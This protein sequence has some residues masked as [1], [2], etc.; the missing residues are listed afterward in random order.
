MTR[1]SAR[2][3]V[4]L[5]AALAL[6]LPGLALGQSIPVTLSGPASSMVGV[7]FVAPIQVDLS[8]RTERLGSFALRIKWNP[9]VV[10]LKGGANGTF[11]DVI[12]YDD[13]IPFGVIHMSGVNPAGVGGKVVLAVPRFNPKVA[14]TTTFVVTLQ[15]LYA[16]GTFA[17]LRPDAVVSNRSYCPARGRFGDIESDGQITSRDGLLA[18]MTA[19]GLPTPGFDGTVGDVDGDGQTTPRDALIILSNVVGLD[20]SPFRLLRVAP[21]A[22]GVDQLRLLA[23]RPGDQELVTGQ[24]IRFEAY[25]TDANTNSQTLT[26]LAW[27]TSN[28]AVATVADGNVTAATPGSA[29]VTAKEPGG[30]QGSVTITVIGARHTH[31][32][33][34]LAIAEANRTGSSTLPFATIKEGLSFAAANDTVRVRAGR[35]VEQPRITVPVV[36]HGETSGQNRAVIASGARTGA[37]TALRVGAGARYEVRNLVLEAFGLGVSAVGTDTAVIDSLEFNGFPGPC[38]TGAVLAR[39][40]HVLRVQHSS[41]FGGGQSACDDGI[42]VIDSARLVVVEDTHISYFASNGIYLQTVDSAV[43]RRSVIQDDQYGLQAYATN[44]THPTV[45]LL[46]EDNRFQRNY[47]G[48]VYALSLR[49]MGTARNVFDQVNQYYPAYQVAGTTAGGGYIRISAD[50]VLGHNIGSYSYYG[51][52]V[53]ANGFDSAGVDGMRVIGAG[54]GT[55][56]NVRH[57]RVTNSSFTEMDNVQAIYVSNA[58]VG[59]VVVDSVHITGSSLCGRCGY[60]V[61]TYNVDSTFVNRLRAENLSYGVYAGDSAVTVTNSVFNNVYQAVYAYGDYDPSPLVVQNVTGSNVGYGIGADGMT[62]RIDGVV[63]AA[64]RSQDGTGINLY[65]GRAD[66]VRNSSLADFGDGV[67]FYGTSMYAS[68]N[69]VLRPSSD[70]FYAEGTGVT[71]SVTLLNNSVTCDGSGAESAGGVDGYAGNHR[72]EGNTVSGCGWG[73]YIEGGIAGAGVRLRNNTIALSTLAEDPGVWIGERYRAEVVGNTISGG[74]QYYSGSIHLNGTLPGRLPY[75]R[76]DSNTIRNAQVWAIRTSYV[77][78]LHVRGNLIEDLTQPCCNATAGAISVEYSRY[79]LQIKKNT[80]HRIHGHGMTINQGFDSATAVVD[81]NAISGAD[82]AAVRVVAGSLLMR[83]NNIRNNARNGVTIPDAA[84]GFTLVGNAFKGNLLYAVQSDGASV[85]AQG[86]WWGV[87]GALPGT[88]GADAVAGSV[89]ASSPLGSE[90]TDVPS[91]APPFMIA[92]P[93]PSTPI[94]AARLPDATRLGAAAAKIA[95]SERSTSPVQFVAPSRTTVRSVDPA[96]VAAGAQQAQQDE[97]LE[98]ARAVVRERANLA[99]AA[100]QAADTLRAAARERR[101]ADRKVAP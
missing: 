57:L 31:W 18:L 56:S 71:D 34:A 75:A 9:A 63:F 10:E 33:D 51:G 72:Y 59:S 25:G 40:V 19:V 3:L 95:R 29:L 45:A 88:A 62:S 37:D 74:A 91:L 15:E 17:D 21:G 82:T 70:G 14:D 66:T 22:C 30:R 35:Y 97:A 58:G 92:R 80:L 8:G 7:E 13:S 27:S 64:D 83:Q 61:R 6:S 100:R 1:R 65:G 67:D 96:R 81:T 12:S 32:V 87:D 76:V 16:A 84:G 20:T 47:Y 77:D 89:D 2:S 55:F 79:A 90:P 69:T 50:S 86:N 99:A 49:S 85:S 38:G 44:L 5:A 73:M 101:R 53:S 98:A 54:Q 26:G 46:L 48:G 24:A 42:Q 68:G 36:L 39:S 94:G 93:A 23:V 4:P 43:I 11:G 41:L 28:A 78:S 60:G 52:W